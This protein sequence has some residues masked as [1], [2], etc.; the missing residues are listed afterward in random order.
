MPQTI[1]GLT[2]VLINEEDKSYVHNV[3]DWKFKSGEDNSIE[4]DLSGATFEN[5]YMVVDEETLFSAME[6]IKKA[7]GTDEEYTIQRFYC[8]HR[9]SVKQVVLFPG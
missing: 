6:N 3:G 7:K 5:K 1:K 4:I 8:Y 2:V 9:K